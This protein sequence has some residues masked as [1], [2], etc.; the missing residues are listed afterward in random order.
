VRSTGATDL[1]LAY[2]LAADGFDDVTYV[3]GQ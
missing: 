1:R 3:F 2:V